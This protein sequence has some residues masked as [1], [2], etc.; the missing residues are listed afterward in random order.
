MSSLGYILWITSSSHRNPFRSPSSP[1]F[2]YS[3][4]L[5]KSLNH[6]TLRLLTSAQLT[7]FIVSKKFVNF[8]FLAQFKLSITQNLARSSAKSAT[9]GLKSYNCNIDW[10]VFYST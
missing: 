1:L 2:G 8:S 3:K 9:F 10:N 7:W 6:L 4:N 5:Q